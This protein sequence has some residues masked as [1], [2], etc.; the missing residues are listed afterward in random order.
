MNEERAG[1][2]K[3][4]TGEEMRGSIIFFTRLSPDRVCVRV[5]PYVSM[6]AAAFFF[7]KAAMKYLY[8]QSSPINQVERGRAEA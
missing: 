4:R 5:C 3:K 8:L 1:E 7:Y 6:C 2:R